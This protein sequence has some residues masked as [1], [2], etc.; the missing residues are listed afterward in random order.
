MHPFAPLTDRRTTRRR[1]ALL[2]GLI[3]TAMS[4]SPVTA[5]AQAGNR[6]KVGIVDVDWRAMDSDQDKHF[7]AYGWNDVSENTRAL[8]DMLTT[9]LVQTHKFDVIE[10]DRMALILEEQ[11]LSAAGITPGSGQ[12]SLS[13]VDYLVT[14]A[15]TQYG[16]LTEEASFGGFGTSKS[17]ATM[18][19]DVR[20]IDAENGRLAVATSV[21]ADQD[22]NRGFEA[23]GMLGGRSG[24]AVRTSDSESKLMGDVMRSVAMGI[25]SLIVE[26]VYPIRVAAVTGDDVILNYGSG[27]LGAGE[28]VDI[29]AEGEKYVDPATGEVLGTERHFVATARVSSTEDRFS[30]A[31]VE[32]SKG[33]IELGM[34]AVMVREDGRGRTVRYRKLP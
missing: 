9:A 7:Q 30:R 5:L 32:K 23:Q 19:V 4:I 33:V 12:L 3:G 15:V 28:R 29:Y 26:E 20:V 16:L 18:A 17:T 11:G 31:R 25:T 8:V 2:V 10:R 13:G 22:G 21:I 24:N 1:T 6:V 27:L 14:G 34:V